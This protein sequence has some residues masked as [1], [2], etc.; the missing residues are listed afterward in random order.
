MQ[1][2]SK[3]YR[4]YWEPRLGMLSDDQQLRLKE[5]ADFLQQYREQH[6]REY[7]WDFATKK[8]AL[9]E[10]DK[11]SLHE[12]RAALQEPFNAFWQGEHEEVAAFAAY[13]TNLSDVTRQAIDTYF[14]RAAA[15]LGTQNIPESVTFLVVGDNRY[16]AMAR[17][18]EKCATH[19][20]VTRPSNGRSPVAMLGSGIHETTHL[21][22]FS[23]PL[24]ERLKQPFLDF[25]R[26][27]PREY[28]TN[29]DTLTWGAVRQ[30]AVEPIIT[31]MAGCDPSY[32]KTHMLGIDTQEDKDLR[33]KLLK[34]ELSDNP[35]MSRWHIH[36]I[37]A[38]TQSLLA[39]YLDASLPLDA[40]FINNYIALWKAY[41]PSTVYETKKKTHVTR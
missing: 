15:F 33:E 36:A 24:Q 19:V 27:V 21:F 29:D 22:E 31:A 39:T 5:Y 4:T 20:V 38:R 17:S 23:S 18:N 26:E 14:K 28:V 35:S 13:L 11:H 9:N 41:M 10:G 1:G 3:N 6:E 32:F 37:A 30:L 2:H 12:I 16:G 8:H 40:D 34:R 7:F 25:A